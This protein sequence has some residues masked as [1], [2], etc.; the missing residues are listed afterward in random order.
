[1]STKEK[2]TGAS[3]VLTKNTREMRDKKDANQDRNFY[4]K[5]GVAVAA[6]AVAFVLC[7]LYSNDNIRKGM[8][9]VTVDGEKYSATELDYYYNTVI[10]QYSS[11]LSYFGVDPNQDL[12]AQMYS[13][14]QSW[15]DYFREEA[16]TSLTHTAAMYH[17]AMADENYSVSDELQQ[18]IDEYSAS[19]DEY[20]KTYSMTREQFLQKQFGEKMTDEIFM[21]HVTMMFVA[22]DYSNDYKTNHVYSDDEMKA[23]YDEHKQDIDLA[24]YEVLTVNADYTGIEGKTDGS[25]D[26]EPEYTEAQDKQAMDAAMAT[27]NAF[28]DRVNSGE[29]LADIAK[30]YGE[31]YYSNKEDV[32][33]STFTDYAFNDWVFNDI[34]TIGEASVVEDEAKNC[35]YVVVL[36]DRYRPDYNT[37]DVRH[38]LIKPAANELSSDDEGYAAE[39]EQNKAQASQ[40]ATEILNEYL[41]GPQSENAFADLAKENSED[42]NAS[43]GGLYTQ[44]YK[45]QMVDSFE[46][47]CFDASRKS[48]DTGIVETTYGY[49]VMYFVGEDLPYWEVRCISGMNTQWENNIYDNANAKEHALGIKAV[50]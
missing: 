20:S 41:S 17:A 40:K 38:I 13:D 11:Y 15:G 4:I 3:S 6:L 28:L 2:K 12:D 35:W 36:N 29:K 49:H 16:I 34:R 26:E 31:N 25:T 1:M 33:Y 5:C 46:N 50:G 14:E 9:A 39:T 37:V 45:G 30:E 47:W 42:S 24:S 23:Y 7:F 22:A 8:T 48:G 27:A 44:V 43:E 10:N 19:V 32:S 21:K 18:Q